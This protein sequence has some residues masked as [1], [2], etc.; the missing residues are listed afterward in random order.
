MP[1]E[2]EN[3]Q[4][5][6]AVS[7]PGPTKTRNAVS[8][9]DATKS[10]DAVSVSD[11]PRKLNREQRIRA[12]MEALGVYSPA[13]DTT[14]HALAVTERRLSRAEKEW[15]RNGGKTVSEQV[16]RT[17]AKYTAKDPYYTVVESLRRDVTSLQNQLGLTPAGLARART[18]KNAASMSGPSLLE[19]LLDDARAYALDNAAQF[20][21]DVDNYVNGVLSGETVACREIVQA[22]ERYQRDLQNPKWDFRPEPANEI[23]GIIETTICH[24]QGEF[25]DATPLRGTPFLL[26]PYHKFIIYN[27]FGFYIAGTKERRFKEAVDFVPR[28]NIKTTFA[29]ALAWA[30]ALYERKSGSKV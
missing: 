4:T 8:E 3:N 17:G 21:N 12:D 16:N 14:I 22:C 7:E 2:L 23:I 30:V 29:V 24:K 15:K 11:K 5:R 27:L 18:K 28:K 20:Q 9:P 6:D 10:R 26:L 19:T 25:L 1:G 13:F